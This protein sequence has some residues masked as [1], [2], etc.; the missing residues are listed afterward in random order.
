[1]LACWHLKTECVCT[2]AASPDSIYHCRIVGSKSRENTGKSVLTAA[3]WINIFWHRWRDVVGRHFHL[4]G[5]TGW[6]FSIQRESFFLCRCQ[7]AVAVSGS[8]TRHRASCLFNEQIVKLPTPLASPGFHHP[9]CLTRVNS[10]SRLSCLAMPANRQFFSFIYLFF[11]VGANCILRDYSECFLKTW[12]RFKRE[13]NRLSCVRFT[14]S[15]HCYNREMVE[16]MQNSFNSFL[17]K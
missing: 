7:A 1:M 8:S 5:E 2:L 11:T 12:H 9:I 3:E 4:T 6:Q 16:Q 10:N 15:N 14:A 17:F 13:L